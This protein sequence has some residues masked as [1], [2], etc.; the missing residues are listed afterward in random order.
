MGSDKEVEKNFAYPDLLELIRPFYPAQ[1][2]E[3]RLDWVRENMTGI[4]AFREILKQNTNRLPPTNN[5]LYIFGMD[6]LFTVS[7]LFSLEEENWKVYDLIQ[8]ADDSLLLKTL[9]S[10]VANLGQVEARTLLYEAA[11][12]TAS[13]MRVEDARAKI[14]Q[15]ASGTPET[16]G[17]RKDDVITVSV[18]EAFQKR[19]IEPAQPA[20]GVP[21]SKG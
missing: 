8:E 7:A 2:Y 16:L 15:V 9:S 5:F 12:Q 1:K 6:A 20:Q 19:L 13:M 11:E 4:L 3:Q 21:Q 17:K 18:I 10:C 14:A